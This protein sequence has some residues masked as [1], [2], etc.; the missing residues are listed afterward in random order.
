MGDAVGYIEDS[1][2]VYEC[3]ANSSWA[4][5]CVCVHVRDLRSFKCQEAEMSVAVIEFRV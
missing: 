5:K 3:T 2:C 1:I 4:C